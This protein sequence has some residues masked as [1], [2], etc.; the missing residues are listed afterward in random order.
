[1]G[2]WINEAALTCAHVERRPMRTIELPWNSDARCDV[3]FC[4][5]EKNQGK[6]QLL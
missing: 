2:G 5:G 3:V 4:K 1:M 6:I